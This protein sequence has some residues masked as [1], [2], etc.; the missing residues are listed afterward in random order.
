MP[1]NT[2]NIIHLPCNFYSC[3]DAMITFDFDDTL[4]RPVWSEFELWFEPSNNPNYDSIARLL[5]FHE[6]GQEIRI[7]T[8][9]FCRLEIV[10][11]VEK[12]QLPI[13]AIH[14]TKGELK[15][16][17]LFSIGSNLH[18]DDSPDEAAHNQK[19]K[20]PTMLVSYHFDQVEGREICSFDG[21]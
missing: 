2:K 15:G 7:V 19:W 1:F 16:E 20:I 10:D 18:F 14:C 21:C 3:L 4:T 13:S 8:T 5:S 12:Y 9:R 17:T 11:F 6:Q